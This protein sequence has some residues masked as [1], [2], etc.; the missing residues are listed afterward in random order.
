MKKLSFALLAPV[1][2]TVLADLPARA[3]DSCFKDNTGSKMGNAA[4]WGI[5][6]MVI[7]MFG[8]LGTLVAAGFYFNWRAKNP[9]PDYSELL[10][11]DGEGT[12]PLPD[13]S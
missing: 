1:L 10:E 12:Q 7:I 3:C 8:M 13:A 5:I 11:E 6:A 4:N 9:L 2:L